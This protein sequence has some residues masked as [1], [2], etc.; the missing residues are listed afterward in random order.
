[1][2]APPTSCTHVYLCYCSFLS[3]ICHFCVLFS[4][5]FPGFFF[6]VVVLSL[7]V[8]LLPFSLFL[9]LVSIV[10]LDFELWSPLVVV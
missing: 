4:V 3:L 10:C 6:V 8:F 9:F 1:M 5:S 7:E 2:C